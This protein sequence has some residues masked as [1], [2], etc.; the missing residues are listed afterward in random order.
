MLS[1]N[2]DL[3]PSHA[4]AVEVDTMGTIYPGLMDL[5]NH[6]A[7]NVLTMWDVPDK[8]PN[9]AVW[10]RNPVYQSNVSLPISKALRLYKSTA[11]AIVRFVEAKALLGCVTTGQGMLTRNRNWTSTHRGVMRNVERTQDDRLPEAGGTIMDLRVSGASGPENIRKFR[12]RITR[13]GL[14]AYFYHLSEGVDERSRQHFEN[15]NN[16]DLLQP[17]LIGIH[18]L[19][20]SRGDLVTMGNKGCK[21]VWSPFSNLLLYGQTLDLNALKES[22]VPFSIGCDWSP[23]GG[24]NMLVELKVAMFENKRQG[25]PFNSIDLVAAATRKPAEILGWDHLLGSVEAG[26]LAD[27]AVITGAS[28]DPY[29]QLLKACEA[30]IGLILIGGWPRYGDLAFM[31]TLLPDEENRI[32][33]V[34]VRNSNKGFYLYYPHSPINDVTLAAAEATL[35]EAASDLG[36]FIE[37]ME[38]RKAEL[39]ALG[40]DEGPEFELVLDNEHDHDFDPL[41]PEPDDLGAE[42]QAPPAM[43][44][45]VEID[46]LFFDPAVDQ[47]RIDGQ[48]NIPDDLK[49]FIK[50]SYS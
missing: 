36:E 28:D 24:K 42:L 15:L 4:N 41:I 20:L 7:Y 19:A 17:T 12:R 46:T 31:R 30:D 38:E 6:L 40:L 23:S 26:G 1:A 34:S 39:M 10:R 49:A 18:S 5:H 29:D 25:S 48:G 3:P 11:Q 35:K 14:K 21:V 33:K 22:G 47:P 2:E 8:F 27:L 9:R 37:R 13:E 44:S 50:S 32:E 43:A 45:E 16:H